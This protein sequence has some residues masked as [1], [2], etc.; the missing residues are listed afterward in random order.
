MR[1]VAFTEHVVEQDRRV[2]QDHPLRGAVADVALVPQ[3]L[4]L[5]RGLG[6]A[7]QEPRL[8]GDP[9]GQDRV[10]LVGHR[11]AA[12]LARL[13]RL[14]DLGD[15]GVL[16]VA[17][18]GRDALE[19]TAEDG[20]RRE[21]RR[22]PVALDDL[23]AHRVHVEAEVREDLRLEVRRQVAVRADRT[24]DLAGGDRRRRPG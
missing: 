21:E 17:D 22:V 18:L 7:A 13:E 24:A 2:G 6:V 4:V 5:E 10:A 16:E 23:G 19:R 20:D 15:L 9:L 1:P 12:L 14:H 3:R 8:A 11:R